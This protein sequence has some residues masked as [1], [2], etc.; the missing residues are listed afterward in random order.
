MHY[1]HVTDDR[2]LIRAIG[3][4]ARSGRVVEQLGKFGPYEEPL[5]AI[6]P[7]GEEWT[8]D[9]VMLIPQSM[10]DGLSAYE[11][12]H[13]ETVPALYVEESAEHLTT[14]LAD[15]LKLANLPDDEALDEWSNDEL[16]ARD[17]GYGEAGPLSLDTVREQA[18]ERLTE[19]PLC[20]EAA[21]TFEIVL[22]TGGPDRRLLIDCEPGYER[23]HED[24]R[25]RTTYEIKGVRFRYSWG[26][27]VEIPLTGE[28]KEAAEAFAARVVPELVE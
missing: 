13:S 12:E 16:L 19:L 4:G 15:L 10:L 11:W 5:Y 27:S 3:Y 18:D 14:E 17:I 22:G 7:D 21:T 9:T 8:D 2:V 26:N 28:A 20:V 24:P 25:S 23:E 6:H 1:Q